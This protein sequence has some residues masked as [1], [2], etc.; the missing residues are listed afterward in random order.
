MYGA[1]HF[2]VVTKSYF[3]T[4]VAEDEVAG[5]LIVRAEDVRAF[6][7]RELKIDS[8]IVWIRPAAPIS[9][10]GPLKF[11]HEE[12]LD[13]VVRLRRDTS[14]GLTPK[15]GQL[16]EIWIRTDL[17]DCPHLEYAVA[18]ELRHAA[19]KIYCPYAFGDEGRAE[20][21]AY[22]YGYEALKRYFRSSGGL[23]DELRQKID[24]QEVETKKWFQREYPD[25]DYKIVDCSGGS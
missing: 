7:C 3:F 21:D 4:K 10:N 23:S 2:D 13:T 18:H 5:E 16:H 14:G 12:E 15:N 8:Q 20:G 19:Q 22:P 17:A 11:D 6:V 25:G 9:K 1:F 24:T